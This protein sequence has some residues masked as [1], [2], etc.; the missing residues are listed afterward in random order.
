MDALL[1][2]LSEILA[3]E[4]GLHQELLGVLQE[5]SESI[6]QVAPSKLL[7]LQSAKQYLSHKIETLESQRIEVVQK[8]ATSWE[9]DFKDLT[10]SHIISRVSQEMGQLLEG[11]LA[12]LKH[13]VVEIRRLANRNGSLSMARLKS[14]EMSLRFIQDWQKNQQTY[15]DAGTLQS[16]P[17]KVSRASI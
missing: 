17:E 14:V 6:G 12:Q 5:E 16:A 8:I 3:H 10:L 15:S 1:A 7:Q 2:N 9:V 13:L 11:H 4:V